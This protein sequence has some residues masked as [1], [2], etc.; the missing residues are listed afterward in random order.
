MKRQTRRPSKLIGCGPSTAPLLKFLPALT[1]GHFTAEGGARKLARVQCCF[2]RRL[3]ASS[4]FARHIYVPLRLG[5]V[6]I[7][8]R[9]P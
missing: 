9:A 6:E 4:A 7:M 5:K 1:R 2:L 8:A 3:A